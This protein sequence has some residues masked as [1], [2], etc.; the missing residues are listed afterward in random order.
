MT[1][2]EKSNRDEARRYFHLRLEDVR[3]A[4]ADS[5][6]QDSL[7]QEC[8]CV[9]ARIAVNIQLSTGGPGDGFEIIC[10]GS[11]GEPLHGSHYFVSWGFRKEVSLSSQELSDVCNLYA[12]DDARHFLGGVSGD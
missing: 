8:L 5:D 6:K 7:M 2:D 11:T 1:D 4:L 3:E 12:I 9:E 10:D